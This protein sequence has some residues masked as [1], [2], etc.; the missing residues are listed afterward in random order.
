MSLPLERK[1]ASTSAG[2]MAYTDLGDGPPV[3]LIHG[4]PTSAD[5]W[6]RVA[7]LLAQRMRVIVPDLMGYGHSERPVEVDLSEPAQADFIRELLE[8]LAIDELAIVGHDIGGAIAQMLAL[9]GGLQVRTLVLLDSACFD[10]WP[11]EGVRMIQA[12]LPA[13]ETSSFVEDVLRVTFTLGIAH[14]SR[15]DSAVLDGFIQPWKD[16]P[17][18]FFRAV[19]ALTGKG[20]AGREAELAALDLPVLL[21]WGEDDP[22]VP[23]ELAERLGEVFPFSTLAI[24]PGCSH[25]ITEDAPQTVGPL[26][27][28][29][30]R[31]RY[32]GQ[33]HSHGQESGPVSVF[34]E[35]PDEGFG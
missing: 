14:Q 20:L 8:T 24:L 1:R 12:A 6:D 22:F 17:A 15:I 4:F 21:I 26:I 29:F 30:L 34:L 5:L 27:H 25:F 19:R 33:S 32:L 35:R 31:V 28:E 10:A 2:E 18:A 11:V 16:D 7:W 9:D 3:L 13:Q 23:A